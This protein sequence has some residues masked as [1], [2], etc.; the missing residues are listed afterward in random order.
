MGRLT[1]QNSQKN[2]P[3][4]IF[5]KNVLIDENDGFLKVGFNLKSARLL[6]THPT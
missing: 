3:D 2:D 4:T 1:Y 5:K 6:E